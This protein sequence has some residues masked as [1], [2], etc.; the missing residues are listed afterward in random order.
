MGAG[1]RNP[2]PG[3]SQLTAAKISRIP[4]ARGC[5][6]IPGAYAPRACP[7]RVLIVA[8]VG[9]ARLACGWDAGTGAREPDQRGRLKIRRGRN[10][11]FSTSAK[12]MSEPCAKTET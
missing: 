9:Q 6:K 3:S 2:P 4:A 5:P 12:A 8:Q 11:P 7:G 10:S 1:Y